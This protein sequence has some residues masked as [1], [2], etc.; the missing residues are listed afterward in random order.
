MYGETFVLWFLKVYMRMC[1][2]S[3]PF[4]VHAVKALQTET[5]PRD[6]A[7]RNME[8]PVR[9]GDVTRAVLFRSLRQDYRPLTLSLPME[10]PRWLGQH[11]RH[12]LHDN[13]SR[14]LKT[15]SSLRR[16]GSCRDRLIPLNCRPL[17]RLS[18][19]VTVLAVIVARIA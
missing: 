12:D 18:V 10:L 9:T 13:Y 8:K 3:W 16:F 19:R 11:S 15:V 7:N 6:T 4:I 17:I 2:T 5:S 1:E 14:Q